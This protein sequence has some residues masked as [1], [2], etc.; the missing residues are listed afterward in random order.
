MRPTLAPPTAPLNERIKR[1]IR[2]TGPL[3]FARFME[4]ALYDES[5]GYY[6][7]GGRR[8]GTGGDYFTASD[9]GHAF[10]RAMA[11]SD[12]KNAA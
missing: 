2:E 8:L 6:S 5:E 4:L 1:E 11:A 12:L 7:A 9:V 10:G 3:S